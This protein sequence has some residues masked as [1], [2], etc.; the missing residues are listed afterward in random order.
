MIPAMK[1]NHQITVFLHLNATEE[2]NDNGAIGSA[3]ICRSCRRI[4]PLPKTW[5]TSTYLVIVP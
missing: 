5:F 1:C 2:N 3:A 4:N